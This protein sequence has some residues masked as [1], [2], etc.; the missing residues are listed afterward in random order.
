MDL[1]VSGENVHFLT[2]DIKIRTTLAVSKIH[3]LGYKRLQEKSSVK[4]CN[5]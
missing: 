1:L 4:K 5:C 3:R 2:T